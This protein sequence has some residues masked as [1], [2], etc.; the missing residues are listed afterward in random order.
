MRAELQQRHDGAQLAS[1]ETPAP[2][3]STTSGVV[4]ASATIPGRQMTVTSIALPEHFQVPNGPSGTRPGTSQPNVAAQQTAP[5]APAVYQQPAGSV[6][7]IHQTVQPPV[8][9]GAATMQQAPVNQNLMAVNAVATRQL[10]A[11]AAPVGIPQ[12]FNTPRGSMPTPQF[13]ASQPMPMQ[14]AQPYT[15]AVNNTMVVPRSPMSPFAQ[16]PQQLSAIPQQ[17]MATIPQQQGIAV[18][19]QQMGMMPQ[20][21]MIAA[22]QQLPVAGG[23][24]TTVSYPPAATMP[25]R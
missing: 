4:S 15:S 6:Q 9:N 1:Y 25:L 13:V 3:T 17:Q 24:R 12:N 5:A 20:Q 2:Q 10:P 19:Q 18:P 8:T 11:V 7:P 21:Q 14:G 22:P 23:V 16:Q